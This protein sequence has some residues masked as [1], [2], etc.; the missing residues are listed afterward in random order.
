M[1]GTFSISR[2]AWDGAEPELSA[3]L[4]FELIAGRKKKCSVGPPGKK[5]CGGPDKIQET[6]RFS[7]E[8]RR[9]GSSL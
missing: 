7:V 8:P 3:P 2:K 6:E 9:E 4:F 5:I 1:E